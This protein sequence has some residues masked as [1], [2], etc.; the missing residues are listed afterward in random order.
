MGELLR[1]QDGFTIIELI[2]VIVILGILS[3]IVVFT[4]QNFQES[5]DSKEE[6]NDTANIMRRLE[7]AYTAQDIGSPSYPS[8]VEFISDASTRTRTMTRTDAEIFKAPGSGDLSVT[9]A[10]NTN[11]TNPAGSNTPSLTQYVYQPLKADGTLC[12]ASPSTAS[13]N[14]CVRFFLYYKNASTSQVVKLK[15]LHQQ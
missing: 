12:T 6:A 9:A 7:T 5:A 11:A 2:I 3:A 4:P 13:T 8:T 1:Q 15:S 10:T 14:R